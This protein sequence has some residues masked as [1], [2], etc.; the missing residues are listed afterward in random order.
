MPVGDAQSGS[1]FIPVVAQ[2]D[3]VTE[4]ISIHNNNNDTQVDKEIE[5]ETRH[6]SMQSTGVSSLLGSF[7]SQET[8]PYFTLI[9][10]ASSKHNSNS[11]FTQ[12]S[13]CM[14]DGN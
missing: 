9:T 1:N 10:N 13:K 2:D 8:S 11:P 14:C 5:S 6:D 7:L 3:V 12:M 4:G